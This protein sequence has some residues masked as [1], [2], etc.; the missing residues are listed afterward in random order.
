MA[1]VQVVKLTQEKVVRTATGGHLREKQAGIFGTIPVCKSV[2]ADVQ[3]MRVAD[4]RSE[5][6]L[7]QV[8]LSQEQLAASGSQVGDPANLFRGKRQ[9]LTSRS[10]QSSGRLYS[11]THI[12]IS[13]GG[14]LRRPR[15]V[16]PLVSRP[17]AQK[18]CC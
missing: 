13:K 16:E 3:H 10:F 9:R 8:V 6:V 15:S 5:E 17:G 1:Q 11:F 14:Q 7:L 4:N 2:G 12:G 18:K